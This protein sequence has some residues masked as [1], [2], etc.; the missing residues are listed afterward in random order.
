MS[1]FKDKLQVFML[2]LMAG[3]IIAGG[4]FILKLDDYFKELNFYKNVVK[5]FT[6]KSEAKAQEASNKAEEPVETKEKKAKETGTKEKIIT[7]SDS[8]EQN[9]TPKTDFVLDADTMTKY[10]AKDSAHINTN[11]TQEDI[12]IRKDELLATKTIEIASL[13]AGT[14]NTNNAKD[15]LLQKVSG[16]KD[17]K[18]TA[19]QLI[20][21][22][23]WQSPLNYKG[24]KM[25]K[26]KMVLY[27]IPSVDAIKIYSLN[28]NVYIKYGATVCRLEN[29]NEFKPYERITDEAIVSKLK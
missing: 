3:L 10:V 28:D 9:K 11:G 4:F 13:A 5:T 2:G 14:A 7:S 23:L 18:N 19:Q 6:F 27:G 16:I 15:S 1:N 8:A 26:Y 25:S 20:N 22:E 21:V 17:D 24:Y 29:S 12:V